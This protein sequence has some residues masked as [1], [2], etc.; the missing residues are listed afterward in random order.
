MSAIT[1]GTLV[2]VIRGGR[3]GQ[4]FVVDGILNGF[5]ADP[6]GNRTKLGNLRTVAVPELTEVV[7]TEAIQPEVVVKKDSAE[8]VRLC[9]CGCGEA[10]TAKRSIYRQGHDQRHKGLL[11]TA[12]DKEANAEAGAFLVAKGWKTPEEVAIRLAKAERRLNPPTEAAPAGAVADNNTTTAP[13][14]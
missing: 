14:A 8:V 1:V 5:A 11:L 10:I 3:A 13:A 2:E 6:E 12:V 4:Q 7:Q 9:A